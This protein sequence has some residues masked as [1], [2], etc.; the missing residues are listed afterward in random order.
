MAAEDTYVQVQINQPI[1]CVV[2]EFTEFGEESERAFD[3]VY[4]NSSPYP[5]FVSVG[6]NAETGGAG[7]AIAHIGSSMAPDMTAGV[8]DVNINYGIS[9]QGMA[10]LV[11]PGWFYKVMK[12]ATIHLY[13]W[14]EVEIGN[15]LQT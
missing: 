7:I 13:H 14:Y 15:N 4:E 8:C 3:E 5:L 1:G 12:I 10:F 11:P 2:R 9:H 6:I